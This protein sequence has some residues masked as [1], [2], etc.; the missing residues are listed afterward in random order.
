MNRAVLIQSLK[1]MVG[2]V[3]KIRKQEIEGALQLAKPKDTLR[4]NLNFLH[5]P[6]I[7][8]GESLPLLY[9]SV[10]IDLYLEVADKTTDRLMVDN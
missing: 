8:H 4:E 7:Q 2:T 6:K 3:R 10:Y 5:F 1:Q 9:L